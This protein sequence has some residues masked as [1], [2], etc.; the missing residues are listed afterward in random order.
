MYKSLILTVNLVC[1]NICQI[2]T[3]GSAH[4]SSTAPPPQTNLGAIAAIENADQ[5][6]FLPPS[7]ILSIIQAE[8]IGKHILLFSR[9]SPSLPLIW[10]RGTTELFGKQRCVH[11]R[12]QQPEMFPNLECPIT[13]RFLYQCHS[14]SVNNQPL[15]SRQ[16]TSSAC[17]ILGARLPDSIRYLAPVNHLPVR[18]NVF[19]TKHCHCKPSSVISSMEKYRSGILAK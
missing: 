10:N 5:R 4:V 15:R 8:P 12:Q 7:G 6:A 17:P 14:W 11:H 1:S 13:A 2:L 16:A 9:D 3:V 19:I 18:N